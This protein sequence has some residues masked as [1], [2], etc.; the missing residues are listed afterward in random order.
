MVGRVERAGQARGAAASECRTCS[1]GGDEKGSGGA[2]PASSERMT[3]REV[4]AIAEGVRRTNRRTRAA[5]S[6]PCHLCQRRRWRAETLTGRDI[7][8]RLGEGL[9]RALPRAAQYGRRRALSVRAVRKDRRR[10][11]WSDED[12][13]E[14]RRMHDRAGHPPSRQRG[15]GI[16][17]RYIAPHASNGA[18]CAVRAQ[19]STIHVPRNG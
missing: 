3:R 10:V 8:S 11:V 7:L 6:G 19:A 16:A 12:G 15:T 13:T 14:N 2:V 4:R 17:S 9:R 18:D 1:D 5:T